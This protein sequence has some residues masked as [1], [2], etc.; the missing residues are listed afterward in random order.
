MCDNFVCT[1]DSEQRAIFSASTAAA[2]AAATGAALTAAV[3]VAADS[4]SEVQYPVW[5]GYTWLAW[6]SIEYITPPLAGRSRG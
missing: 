5:P 1:P 6:I 2:A 3:T 4:S